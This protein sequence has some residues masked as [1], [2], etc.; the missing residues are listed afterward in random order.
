VDEEP[1]QLGSNKPSTRPQLWDG[2]G[3]GV[4]VGL[5]PG[6]PAGVDEALLDGQLGSRRPSRRPQLDV[7]VGV[8]VGVASLGSPLAL[9]SEDDEAGSAAVELVGHEGSRRLSRSP[10]STELVGAGAGVAD[11]DP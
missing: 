5:L 2:D 8:G 11:D 3:V 6:V 1:P 4:D 10:Q 9:G 7:G